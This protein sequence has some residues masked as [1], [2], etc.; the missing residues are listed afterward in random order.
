MC[1]FSLTWDCS[2]CAQMWDVVRRYREFCAVDILV[3]GLA[4]P[5]PFAV[6]LQWA[7]VSHKS[8]CS[9]ISLLLVGATAAGEVSVS[10]AAV[11]VPS[12]QEVHRLVPI[13]RLGRQ[14]PARSRLLHHLY[15]PQLPAGK[16]LLRQPSPIAQAVDSSLVPSRQLVQDEIIDSFLEI[17]RHILERSRE[18]QRKRTS[19]DSSSRSLR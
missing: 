2:I 8:V 13:N 15:S 7:W 12:E 14:T 5:M 19:L 16:F 9:L 11:S 3:R 6:N 4:L 17:K 18:Q 10:S 1:A